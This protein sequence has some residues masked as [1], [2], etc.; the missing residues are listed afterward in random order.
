MWPHVHWVWI[1][2]TELK[3]SHSSS[4][5]SGGG[6]GGGGLMTLSESWENIGLLL[7]AE[8]G[9]G[10]VFVG[11]PVFPDDL[12]G[13]HVEILWPQ[14]PWRSTQPRRRWSR[15]LVHWY[16]DWLI[17]LLVLLCG[18]VARWCNGYSIG[19]KDQ[20]AVTLLSADDLGKV[21]CFE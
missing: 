12:H 7:L 1:L 9:G 11:R 19:L 20:L 8:T 13:G 21:V 6:G 2:A 14:S 3:L 5:S 10:T 17:R 4:S 18:C 15:L 16:D